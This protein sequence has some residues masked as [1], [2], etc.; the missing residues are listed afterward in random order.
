[1]DAALEELAERVTGV[2]GLL[3]SGVSLLRDERMEFTVAADPA[4]AAV[5]RIQE[6]T[7]EGP[8]CTAAR[9]GQVVTIPDLAA[10]ENPWPAYRHAARR[11]G[12]RAVA[13]L[14][15][16]L[17]AT[18]VGGLNLYSRSPR[19]WDPHD[20]AAATVLADM[21]TAYLINAST[22]RKQAELTKQLQHALDARVVI[23]QAKGILANRHQI[24]VEAAY[25]RIRV[26]SRARRVT[27]RAVAAAVVRLGLDPSEV[28]NPTSGPTGPR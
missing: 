8:C 9:T 23:E 15:M 27:V 26:H 11:A 5:E 16:R 24:S 3:G 4:I 21:A 17:G 10:A 6:H 22:N 25:Q 2:L 19:D 20:V 7:Q 18:T 14:P 28:L 1:M 13:A 12:V